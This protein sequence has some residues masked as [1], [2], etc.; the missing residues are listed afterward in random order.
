MNARLKH[1]NVLRAH[2]RHELRLHGP[3][4]HAVVNIVKL[5]VDEEPLF[6]VI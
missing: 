4:F 3:C 5:M 2:F 6:N 1:F